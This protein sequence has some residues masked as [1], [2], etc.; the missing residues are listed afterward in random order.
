[1]PTGIK[2]NC[3]ASAL[4][5]PVSFAGMGGKNHNLDPA[6]VRVLKKTLAT[7]PQPQM[8]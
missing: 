2:R 8:K 6:T 7:L 1:M 3:G 5:W 4:N